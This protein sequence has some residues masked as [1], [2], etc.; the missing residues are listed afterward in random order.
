MPDSLSA[1]PWDG[2]AARFTPQQWRES[3]LVDTDDGA[4]DAKSRYKLPVREPSGAYNRAALGAR[5]RAW[6]QH[7]HPR[8]GQEERRPE[9]GESLQ[10]LQARHPHPR[11]AIWR[12]K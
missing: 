3:C 5:G 4:P 1:R 10:P 2:D 6:R 7:E 12:C 8:L 9:V 11:S